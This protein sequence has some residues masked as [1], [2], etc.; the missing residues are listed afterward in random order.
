M[1]INAKILN[2][3]L[4]NHNHQYIKEIIHHDQLGFI[5]GMQGWYNISK[6]IN[7]IHHINKKKNNNHMIISIDV[8][9]AFDK[10]QH[11]FMITLSKVGV[12]G[13]Y[14]NIIKAICE[15]LTA[16]II[17]N[18]QKLKSFPLRLGRRRVCLLSLLLL[19]IILE[20]V[21][22]VIKQEK[23]IKGIQIAKEA[24]KPS[25]F[26]HDMIVY[27]KK[28]YRLHQKLLNLISEFHKTEGYKVNIQKLKAFLY[29]NNEISETEMRTKIPFDIAT[30]KTKYLGINLTKE[31]KD[32]YSE[33]YTTLKK[34]KLIEKKIQ[35][36]G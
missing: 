5:P 9:K 26:A 12:E 20:V 27:I 33:N 6:S 35:C 1:N 14:L 3:M 4:A 23:E 17:L 7:V 8:E 11:P 34:K 24:M 31:V 29:T 2:K 21:A 32:L 10:L 16:N 25:L 28:P 15:K 19:S 22:T 13:A 30:R 18:G 36:T